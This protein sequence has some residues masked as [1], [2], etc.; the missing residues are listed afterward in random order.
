MALKKITYNGSSKVIINLC[1]MVN[2]LIDGASSPSASDVSYD[3]TGSGLSADDVQE[4][5]DELAGDIP[6]KTSDLTNDSGF[7]T[8]AV[9]NLVNYYLKSETYTQAEVDALISAISTMHFEVVASL[10]V[11]DIQTNVIYLVPSSDPGTQNIYDEYINTTGTSAGWELIGSTQVDLSNYVTTQDLNTA[12]S[13]YVTSTDL[14]TILADIPI[15]GVG[16]LN[17]SVSDPNPRITMNNAFKM[18]E[19]AYLSVRFKTAM[20]FPAYNE[21]LPVATSV[22]IG[23]VT[24]SMVSYLNRAV[25]INVGD[26]AII[27]YDGTTL[28]IVDVSDSNSSTYTEGD[29]I[30]ISA[31]NAISVD[32]V[33]TEASTRANIASGDTLATIW[34][35]IKKFFS[36]LKTVAFTGAYADL[37][38]QP[39]IPTD[40]VSKAN[41]GTFNGDI[42]INHGN[43]STSVESQM[44]LGNNIA[45]GTVGASWGSLRIYGKGTTR[46]RL[47]ASNIT[48]HRDFEF[49]N[50]AGTLAL[51]NINNNFSAK[52]TINQGRGSTSTTAVESAL[53]LGSSIADGTAGASYGVLG[54]YGKGTAM[55]RL[56]A[57]NITSNQRDFQFPNKAGTLALTSDLPSTTNYAYTASDHSSDA[58][59]NVTVTIQ[60]CNIRTYGKVLSVNLDFVLSASVSLTAW[61]TTPIVDITNWGGGSISWINGGV[62][63]SSNGYIIGFIAI[64]NDKLYLVA[65][66]PVTI[67]ASTHIL[68]NLTYIYT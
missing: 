50:V 4:A 15:S 57:N 33:F 27:V 43:T 36:D 46:A 55:A 56:F 52:Q 24:Y 20:S 13:D 7:I 61:S 18:A 3:N 23:T 48:A 59:R 1:K 22:T 9:N 68:G 42:T 65:I 53:V 6:T 10:P 29:G 8:N 45:D 28:K 17:H 47:M 41:G 63:V 37:T 38:G 66:S 34:G 12:L 64:D 67:A 31:Q 30:D 62:M 35:K 39:T 16:E 51:V 14:T 49:P 60:A 40:F 21:Q 19:G 32:T 5:I 25:T 44:V 11:S 58:F 54:I 2:Q 26:I